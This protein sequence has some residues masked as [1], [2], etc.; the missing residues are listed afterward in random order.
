MVFSLAFLSKFNSSRLDL[1]NPPGTLRVHPKRNKLQKRPSQAYIQTLPPSTIIAKEILS[2]TAMGNHLSFE[3]IPRPSRPPRPTPARRTPSL[4]CL[5]IYQTFTVANLEAAILEDEE[6]E[7]GKQATSTIE[8]LSRGTG[9]IRRQRNT[10]PAILPNEQPPTY[11]RALQL[12]DSYRSILPDYES[13]EQI[14]TPPHTLNLRRRQQPGQNLGRQPRSSTTCITDPQRQFHLLPSLM[15]LPSPPPEEIS[16]RPLTAPSEA[17]SSSSS[18]AVNEPSPQRYPA[19]THSTQLHRHISQVADIESTDTTS[20]EEIINL[21]P[22]E[23]IR[24]SIALQI[25]SNLLID[26]LT[27]VLVPPDSNT[28][29]NS[30]ARAAAKLQVLMM[31][32]AYE[33][34]LDYWK[35]EISSGRAEASGGGG[36]D[37]MKCAGDAVDI[38]THWL[39]SLQAIYQDEFG[40]EE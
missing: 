26:E 36:G 38:L 28:T 2:E 33:G 24:P 15:E 10:V 1:P 29:Q 12:A 35:E 27:Q 34:L 11:D 16:R 18:T 37:R 14:P 19:I 40:E 31:T 21:S 8:G 39:A 22:S 13:M 23:Y 20:Q 4:P 17:S 5:P 30:H 3:N 6:E 32:E 7:E 25:C 9:G